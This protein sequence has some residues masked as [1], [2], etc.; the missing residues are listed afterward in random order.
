MYI[1]LERHVYSVPPVTLLAL[2]VK[3]RTFSSYHEVLIAVVLLLRGMSVTPLSG[4]SSSSPWLAVPLGNLS[5][6]FFFFLSRESCRASCVHCPL[7]E[8]SDAA[9]ALLRGVSWPV[10]LFLSS[11]IKQSTLL[12][13]AVLHPF[14][15]TTWPIHVCMFIEASIQDTGMYVYVSARKQPAVCSVDHF[16]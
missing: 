10:C 12:T 16:L 7:E 6:C 2:T 3:D 1:H 13:V 8:R 11:G 15:S 14:P 5:L 9:T 4:S